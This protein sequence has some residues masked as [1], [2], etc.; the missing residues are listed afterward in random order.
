VGGGQLVRGINTVI[1]PR[2]PRIAYVVSRAPYSFWLEF[3]TKRMG[4]RPFLKPAEREHRAAIS[5][6]IRDACRGLA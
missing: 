4:K 2:D 3:G 6:N 1:D 5:K